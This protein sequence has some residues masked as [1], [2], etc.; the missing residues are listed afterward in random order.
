M[1]SRIYTILYIP[2]VAQDGQ[3]RD[4]RL[5]FVYVMVRTWQYGSEFR[6]YD[7]KIIC[8]VENFRDVDVFT[9]GIV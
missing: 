1:A 5:F 9:K 8:V 6:N 7:G 3:V 2:H 4:D